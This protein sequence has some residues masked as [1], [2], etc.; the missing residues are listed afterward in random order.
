MLAAVLVVDKASRG[1]EPT[2]WSSLEG[3][4]TGWML[5]EATEEDEA[6]GVSKFFEGLPLVQRC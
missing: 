1:G 2:A 3:G 6:D 4:C 5:G